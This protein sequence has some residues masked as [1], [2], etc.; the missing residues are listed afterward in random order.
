LRK[1]RSF[2][3]PW[4]FFWQ[5]AI[6]CKTFFHA[7]LL[8]FSKVFLTRTSSEAPTERNTTKVSHRCLGEIFLGEKVIG[9]TWFSNYVFGAWK[10]TTRCLVFYFF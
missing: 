1:I 5:K 8:V 2:D 10:E 7:S 4:R 6:F 3:F 9:V